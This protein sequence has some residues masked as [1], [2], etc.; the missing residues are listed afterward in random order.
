M[1][2]LSSPNIRRVGIVAGVGVGMLG[3]YFGIRN[4]A[5]INPFA[6][7]EG[8]YS[9][10][11]GQGIGSMMR[12][13]DVAVWDK[14]RLVVQF[15]AA[16]I[17]ARKD[18]QFL[19]LA[20]LRDGK[21]Y[22]KG[23]QRASFTAGLATYES[24]TGVFEVAGAPKVWDDKVSIQAPRLTID[25]NREEVRA[26]SGVTGTYG[27]GTFRAANVFFTYRDKRLEA[28][29][30]EWSGPLEVPVQGSATGKTDV[31]IRG[32]KLEILSNPDRTIYYDAEMAGKEFLVRATKITRE[33]DTDIIVAEGDVEYHG[34][35]A[36]FQAPKVTIYN[37]EKRAI[38]TGAVRLL[39]KPEK[40]QGKVT[41]AELPPAQPELPAALKQGEG[42]V[43]PAKEAQ[44]QSD[45]EV[46][47]AKNLRY[48]PVMV[49]CSK[50]EYFYRKGSRKA[51]V[52][53]SPKARQELKAGT[54]REITAHRAVYEEEADLLTL[55]SEGDGQGVRMTN[56]AGDDLVAETITVSTVEGSERLTGTRISGVMKVS[57]EDIGGGS[58]P[59]KPGE[60]KG[61]GG[62]G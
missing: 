45:E 14:G 62:G 24:S 60:K 38:A 47:S 15:S 58:P 23:E 30:V 59:P 49:T 22:D 44:R 10:P 33:M 1:T 53:G 32:D 46:R 12:N 16:Q 9:N 61:G 35:D 27:G 56:S 6:R 7:F 43:D 51:I 5:R 41:P 31:T 36:V 50:I 4:L 20:L 18:Q 48:Y 25:R 21:V 19:R 34:P 8:A 2:L 57:E 17:D 52:T 11:L 3:L 42:A 39:I 28:E 29:D 54:W 26:A 40:D 37:K 13:V 55:F